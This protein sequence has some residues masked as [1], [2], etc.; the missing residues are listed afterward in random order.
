MKGKG[1]CP[2]GANCKDKHFG[3]L[4]LLARL[5]R[6]KLSNLL[7]P[8]ELAECISFALEIQ[9]DTSRRVYGSPSLLPTWIRNAIDFQ[10]VNDPEELIKKSKR[11]AKKLAHVHRSHLAQ[12]LEDHEKFPPRLKLLYK[13]KCFRFLEQLGRETVAE[14][15]ELHSKQEDVLAIIQKMRDGFI[16]AGPIRPA[17]FWFWK[18]EREIKTQLE[19]AQLAAS[20]KP[21]GPPR[22]HWCCE[23]D[24]LEMWRQTQ[25]HIDRGR[26]IQ[27]GTTDDPATG[28]G[29]SHPLTFPVHQSGKIRMCVDF[30]KKSERVIAQERTRL[31]GV[32]ASLEAIC[33]L[34]SSKAERASL[35]QYKSD[36]KH[37]ADLEKADREFIKAMARSERE[38]VVKEDLD[39]MEA[40][41]RIAQQPAVLANDGGVD[42]GYV[43]HSAKRDLSGYYYQFGV[44]D[45]SSN[46]LW[47]PLPRLPGEAETS[48][49]RWA[50]IEST[51]A[52]FG[53][54]VSVCDCVH[55]SEF[56]M[57]IL[58]GYLKLCITMHI[59]DLH[60]SSRPGVLS[61]DEYLMDL[62]LELSG[63][64]QS[65]EKKE[66]HS[67]SQRLLVV[68]GMAYELSIDGSR[69]TVT[70]PLEKVKRLH[71][72]GRDILASFK[73][74]A[75]DFDKLLS[76]RG[77][78]RHVA[79]LNNALSGVV[80]GLDQWADADFFGRAIK[81]K[82]QRD[83]LKR[84]IKSLLYG[85]KLQASKVLDRM[86]FEKPLAHIYT[87]ASVEKVKQLSEKLRAGV[88][89]GLGEF[90]M[91][92]G[93]ILLL[94][95][96]T[97]QTF[98]LHIS[99]L[100]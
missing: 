30:R 40:A 51:R 5:N 39:N 45:P 89:S 96:G 57:L 34:M 19:A 28:A 32:R 9:K 83:S 80:K 74:R 84:L 11:L 22:Q 93:A 69:R 49:R 76:F 91:W 18:P 16:D 35:M 56:L 75:V 42:F 24:V 63:F 94:P 98:R 95:D 99:K 88:R 59:D 21:R 48:A 17:G 14:L 60:L 61:S 65:V 85:Q 68:L 25:K 3:P 50:L 77:L 70:I 15:P 100:P 53:A 20:E 78:F 10:K 47:V 41:W 8:Q 31:M 23:E 1:V 54:L 2:K 44:Q 79:Q 67:I 86:S 92:I 62:L 4:D 52:L 12:E 64:H 71:D 26:W 46:R 7:S 36:T 38:A 13:G 72:M 55:A 27:R 37:D 73:P 82:H 6:N 58:S 81:S 29:A 87:D 66:S 97:R 33:R 90:D 43:P